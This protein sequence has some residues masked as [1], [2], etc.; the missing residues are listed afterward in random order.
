MCP[1][2]EILATVQLQMVKTKS[3]AVFRKEV[4][5]SGGMGW[6]GCIFRLEWNC[7]SY[8]VNVP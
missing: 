7:E 3:V 4:I 1:I 2:Y 8:G 5:P 6:V